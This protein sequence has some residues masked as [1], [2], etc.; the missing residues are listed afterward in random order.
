MFACTCPYPD[1]PCYHQGVSNCRKDADEA[2]GIFFSNPNND[3][4]DS[5]ELEFFTAPEETS[6]SSGA[7]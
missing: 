6:E 1:G 4:G 2:A 3:Q 7:P 5:G